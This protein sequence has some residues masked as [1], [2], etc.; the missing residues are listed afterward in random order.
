[1]PLFPEFVDF[2]RVPDVVHHVLDML[3]EILGE[4]MDLLVL[5]LSLH[6]CRLGGHGAR[7]R[8]VHLN[9]PVLHRRKLMEIEEG[10]LQHGEDRCPELPARLNY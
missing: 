5:V 2:V 3:S 7:L 1:M 6:V 10:G 4:I 9:D 8:L